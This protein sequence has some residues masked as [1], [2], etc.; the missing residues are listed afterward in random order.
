M[1]RTS[2][3]CLPL[4]LGACA[5]TPPPADPV[6]PAAWSQPSSGSAPDWA[7]LLDPQ[8]AALQD[9]ALRANADLQ[10]AA[11]RIVQAQRQA[12]LGGLRLSPSAGVSMNASRPLEQ[13]G[14]TRTIDVGGVPVP[15]TTEQGWSRSYGL[16]LGLGWELDLWNRIAA[17]Q[18]AAAAQV[19]GAEADRESARLLIRSQVA[20]RYWSLA[21]AD[22]QQ[23]PLQSLIAIGEQLLAVQRLRVQE[24]KLAPIE[25]DRAAAS[26]QAARS[27][28]ADLEAERAGQTQQLA[29][30]VGREPLSFQ[31]RASL[32]A[33]A[34]ARWQLPPP[35]EVLERRPDLRRARSSVDAALA[36]RTATEA[37]RY[38]RLSFSAGVSTGGA[39]SRDWL[40][41][42]LGSLAAN[43]V[44]PLIDWRR[45]DLQRD[46]AQGELEI[47][48]LQL[49]DA[50]NKALVEVE[51]QR[52]ETDRL[53]AQADAQAARM[54]E[55]ARAEQLARLRHEV[56]SIGRG[57]L[58]QAQQARM[59]AELASL[60]L[61]LRR[62]LAQAHLARVLAI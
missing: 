4:L 29:L 14:S 7:G 30:L 49:R 52:R 43:L 58:L 25:I 38:P 19:Q 48:A 42:P 31:T 9:E 16:S 59:E 45:L 36:R 28:L 51:T 53:R 57:E 11:L 6:A 60:Q 15:V 27:R 18:R 26:L 5:M 44:V 2:L 24:G 41:Q 61:Q 50:L 55:A 35:A 40:S 54:A 23:A 10:L 8:L 17:T 56:G 34:P 47:A 1:K 22:A 13:Q 37:E 32:P 12:A 39:D 33:A 3:L 21:A 20:E 62:W 46:L